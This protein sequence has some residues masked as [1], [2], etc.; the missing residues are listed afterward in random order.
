MKPLILSLTLMAGGLTSGLVLAQNEAE[1]AQHVTGNT[2][3]MRRMGMRMQI[4]FLPD[5]ETAIQGPMGQG[6][7]QW[8]LSGN[9]LCMTLPRGGDRCGSVS[10]SET[11]SLL[12]ADGN[13][14]TPVN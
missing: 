8:S 2:F 7:G 5:G 6:A 10:I 1:I 14:M 12:T 9:E 3:E 4:T 13:E 11:G